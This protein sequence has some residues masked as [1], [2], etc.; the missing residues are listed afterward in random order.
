MIVELWNEKSSVK[1]MLGSSD[2]VLQLSLE[3]DHDWA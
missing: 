2:L 1:G 3:E